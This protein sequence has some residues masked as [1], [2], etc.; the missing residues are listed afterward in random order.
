MARKQQ[1][2]SSS[3]IASFYQGRNIAENYVRERFATEIGHLVHNRQARF[4]NRVIATV[5]PQRILE[6]ASGPGR[7]TR[8]IRCPGALVCLEYNFGM[9][10]EGRSAC[11][12]KANWIRGDGF[13]LPFGQVFDVVYS[14]RFIRHFHREDRERL[15]SESRRTLRPGGYFLMDAVNEQFSSPMRIAHPEEYPVYDKLY[16]PEQ[17]RKE[18]RAAGFETVELVPIQ[19][20]FR[21]QYRSQTL[22][23]PRCRWAN[24]MVVW[25][26]EQLPRKAGLEW[27]VAARRI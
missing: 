13:Q 1:I 24:R 18:L 20:Y 10:D 22:L 4:V 14:F 11:G 27:M 26:L 23:G 15:Y 17:L 21:W 8:D 16:R 2:S 25:M 7:L 19:K 12:G 9:I 5:Q 6:I 3:A